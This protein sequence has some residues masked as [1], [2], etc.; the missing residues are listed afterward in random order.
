MG[1]WTLLGILAVTLVAVKFI[2]ALGKRVPILE[3]MLLIAGLQWIV[4]PII[5]YGSPSL[6]YKYY[7]YVE[8]AV[9]M[10]YIVP[11][12]ILFSGGIIFG[13]KKTN[14]YDFQLEALRHY[15][16]QGLYI[17]GIGVVFDVVGGSLPG[18]LGF[19]AFILSNFKYAGA[20]ILYYSDRKALK[21]LFYGVILY[22]LVTS[23]TKG[24]FHDFILWSV[25]FYMFWAKKFKPSLM[26]ILSTFAIAGVLLFTLQVAKAAYRME[27]KEGYSGNKVELLFTLM[28]SAFLV[29][30]T[31]TSEFD[32]DIDSNVRLNQGWII[33]A[34]IEHIPKNQPF[35]DGV[36]ITEAI[37]AS[38]L[39]RFLN[40]NKAKAGGRENFRN[41]T[42][43]D[44]GEGTSMGISIIGEAYGNFGKL[45][46]ILFMGVWG[47]FLLRVWRVLL[48]LILENR[49]LV[50]FL[51]LMF[52]QVIK[53][54]TEL[55][56]VLNH[57]I[58]ASIVIWAFF[59]FAKKRLN[60]K[61][62]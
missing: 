20:I 48:R 6:H 7:M 43:L 31:T 33:S 27:L 34:I 12:Y 38:I 16:K 25:F 52:L 58:K 62:T 15:S 61:L 47:Y 9:Y 26:T 59:W 44:I 32:D 19:F 30:E 55:V 42:G 45:G 11:A 53:A 56:V 35:F 46:G 41:F 8:E 49:L 13:L 40:P 10:Q 21:T 23:I 1:I 14:R 5:E 39:P 2:R 18:A 3:L 36:T 4:G 29:D 22:L 24:L 54:E 60:W 28:S 50:A 37:T 17:F 51:P 57:L